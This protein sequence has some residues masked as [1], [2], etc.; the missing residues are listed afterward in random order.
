MTKFVRKKIGQATLA[1]CTNFVKENENHYGSFWGMEMPRQHLADMVLL[2][3]LKD[4]TGQGY[5]SIIED[6]DFKYK[7]THK[8]LKHNVQKVRRTL[9][10]WAINQI[11]VGNL[12]EW[13]QAARTTGLKS[14]VKYAN[15]WFDSTDFRTQGR[16]SVSR[17]SSWWSYKENS[18]GRRYMLAMNGKGRCLR[19]WGGYSP[20]QHDSEFLRGHHQE[21]AEMFDG[22]T[23]IADNHFSEGKKLFNNITFLTNYAKRSSGKKRKRDE[24]DEEGED[25]ALTKDQQAF[26]KDHQHA[27]A[28]VESPFGWMKQKFASLDRPWAESDTSQ[29][30]YLVY[31]AAGVYNHVI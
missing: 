23:V 17:K 7:I 30:D 3:F 16:S 25:V 1:E 11:Q 15:V 31:I 12:T 28:R 13:K 6:I 27:R 10:D 14:R 26:N 20:K 4:L 21:L 2:S 24:D 8:S 18:P 29:L 9:F 19:L 22:A 5:K